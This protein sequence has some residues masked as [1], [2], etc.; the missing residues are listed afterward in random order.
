MTLGWYGVSCVLLALWDLFL[1]LATILDLKV[2]L[3]WDS[4]VFR[5]VFILIAGFITLG[6]AA[7]LGIAGGAL[8]L[9][10]GVAWIVIG[11]ITRTC[12]E[13]SSGSGSKGKKDSSS[14]SS[15]S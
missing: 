8:S 7:D 2:I 5:G 11:I 10:V 15:S 4:P 1:I 6:V 14:S 12:L 9:A 13:G 3:K